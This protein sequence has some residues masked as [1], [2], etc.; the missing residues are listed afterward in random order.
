MGHLNDQ[1]NFTKEEID[2][3]CDNRYFKF[4]E[5][6]Y[7]DMGMPV[8]SNIYA[9]KPDWINTTGSENGLPKCEVTNPVEIEP[10]PEVPKAYSIPYDKPGFWEI[11]SKMFD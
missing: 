7:K 4:W 11:M 8:P 10:M 1:T 3:H 6:A 2:A 9:N 5:E